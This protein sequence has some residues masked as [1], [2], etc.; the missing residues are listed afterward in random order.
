MKIPPEL[1]RTKL[2]DQHSLKITHFW[3]MH[4]IIFHNQYIVFKIFFSRHSVKMS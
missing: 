4:L 2:E 1:Q 3:N